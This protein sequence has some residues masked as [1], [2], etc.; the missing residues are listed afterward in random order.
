M[1][2]EPAQILLPLALYVLFAVLSMVAAYLAVAHWRGRPAGVW[3]AVITLVFFGV[4]L[5][6]LWAMLRGG[7]LL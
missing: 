7:G 3:A 4:L 5:L 1:Q 6:G 2:P